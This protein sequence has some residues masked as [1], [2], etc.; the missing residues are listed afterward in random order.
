M[1]SISSILLFAVMVTDAFGEAKMPDEYQADSI[2]SLAFGIGHEIFYVSG[3]NSRWQNGPGKDAT[4]IYISDT[5]ENITYEI[6]VPNK[7][8]R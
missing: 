3:K 2:G 4:R 7:V 8:Y 6:D 1:K 5:K